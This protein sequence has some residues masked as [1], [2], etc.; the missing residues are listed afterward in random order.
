M[1]H[2]P[3]VIRIFRIFRSC[4]AQPA[5]EARSGLAGRPMGRRLNTKEVEC[6]RMR[7]QLLLAFNLKR[8]LPVSLLENVTHS[9]NTDGIGGDQI[10]Y[11]L[12]SA[13]NGQETVQSVSVM[14]G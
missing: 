12:Q 9:H 5:L 8:Q 2:P 10:K 1:A 6:R 14:V 7:L 4:A 3:G 13:Q 11:P